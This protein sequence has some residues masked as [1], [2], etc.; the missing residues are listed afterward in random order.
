MKAAILAAEADIVTVSLRRQMP[1]TNGGQQ[2][3]QLLKEL[4]VQL[5]PNTAGC[6]NA[7]EA[8]NTAKMSRELFSTNWIKLEVTGD[9]YNLQP[10]PFELLKAAKELAQDG[11]D[12]FPY[13]TSDLVVAQRLLE[14]G[15]R[16]IMPWAA[17]I[18]TG[19]GPIDLLSLET[20]RLRLPEAVL[21][22]DAGLGK[23][24]H[25]AQV[26]QLGYDAVLLNSAVARANRPELMALAFSLAVK[27]GRCGY[28]A[29]LMEER[30]SAAPSTPVIGTPFWH[31]SAEKHDQ[32][33]L[34]AIGTEAL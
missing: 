24:S 12:V 27:A 5:L 25:A 32:R 19:K 2:F 29:G 34:K 15:C 6:R 18:G 31:K 17:P 20:L 9:E 30:A 4:P 1:E 33:S 26:M 8:V 11:F 23:P 22:V 28:E 16:T 21:I 13:T 3:W 7:R 10:D 14:A